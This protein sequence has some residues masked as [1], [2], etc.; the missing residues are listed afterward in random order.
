MAMEDKR[1]AAQRNDGEEFQV[2][3]N[4]NRYLP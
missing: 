4:N 3:A 2:D 1:F